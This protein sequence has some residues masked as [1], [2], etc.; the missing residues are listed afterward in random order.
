[1]F[2]VLRRRTLLLLGL[3][4]VFALGAAARL[5]FP[6][7]RPA[8]SGWTG[9]RRTVYVLDAGH[10][11]EDGGALAA[12]GA[13]ESDI[14]LAVAGKLD[15][16][17]RFLGQETRMTRRADVSIYS[18]GAETLRQ[19]KASDLKNRAEIVNA[20]P[21]GI[22]VSIH[23]NSLPSVPSVHGAQVFY[24]KDA[25]GEVLAASVQRTLNDSV[26]AE[27]AKQEKK[28]DAS[29]YLFD[30]V[31]RPAILVECGFLSNAA[32]ALR[33]RETNYQ[34]TLAVAVAAGLLSAKETMGEGS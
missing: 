26:N 24:G 20:T 29:L 17:L 2:I 19:K 23:Q 30:H 18:S 9:G 8:L 33:L 16:L 12:D 28:I 11:G 14:N 7:A 13:R 22:L 1:M 21:G 10:G 6:A 3:A 27:N 4:L 34:K 31:E 25:A 32:E 15:A 5:S